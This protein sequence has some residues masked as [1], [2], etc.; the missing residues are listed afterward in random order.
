M[1]IRTNYRNYTSPTSTSS[2]TQTPGVKR[3][4]KMPSLTALQHSM[5]KM[6]NKSQGNKKGILL[7]EKAK[8]IAL[9]QIRKI[10][11][12]VTLVLD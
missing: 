5:E 8:W 2:Q 7:A 3:T 11:N 12:T 9:Q 10:H 4:P 6:A 1:H